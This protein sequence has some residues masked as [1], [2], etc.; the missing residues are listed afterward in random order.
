MKC[1]ESYQSE[2]FY[3][4]FNRIK[5]EPRYRHLK[6]TRQITVI[7]EADSFMNNG[8]KRQYVGKFVL[9]DPMIRSEHILEIPAGN[10]YCFHTEI[11]NSSWLSPKIQEFVKEKGTPRLM[12][13]NEYE[14]S[15]ANYNNNPHE[16]QIL[17]GG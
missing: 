11:F 9:E 8:F 7:L 15:L 12:L 17:M 13:A 5:N 10:Y 16:L 1:P 6:L 14:A 4:L 2:D 3:L